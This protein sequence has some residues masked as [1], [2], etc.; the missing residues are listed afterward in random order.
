MEPRKNLDQKTYEQYM[1]FYYLGI[2]GLILSILFPILEVV[3]ALFFFGVTSLFIFTFEQP[4]VDPQHSARTH[5]DRYSRW[6]WL[7]YAIG[8]FIAVCAFLYLFSPINKAI[9]VFLLWSLA[10]FVL[11]RYR[12]R[13]TDAVGQTLMNDYIHE[14]FPKIAPERLDAGIDLLFADPESQ[15]A[16]LANTMGVDNQTAKEVRYSFNVYLRNYQK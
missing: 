10:V 7:N 14:Q 12:T 9:T 16:K 8:I 11:T 13:L 2:V 5:H 1:G 4:E 3:Y 15:T 6:N